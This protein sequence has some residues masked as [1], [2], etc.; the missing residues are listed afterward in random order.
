L[1][2]CHFYLRIDRLFVILVSAANSNR[3]TL[4]SC[5]YCIQLDLPERVAV[6]EWNLRAFGRANRVVA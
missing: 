6:S 2:D 3:L 5:S 1:F 4:Q